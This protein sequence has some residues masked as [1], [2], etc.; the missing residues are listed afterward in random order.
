MIVLYIL[1]AYL[2]LG[3]FFAL[4]FAFYKIS[5]IDQGATQSSVGFK[6]LIIP[7]SILL[8]VIILVKINSVKK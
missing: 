1:L 6:L 5:K 4:W 7:A 2:I 3:F 8:W